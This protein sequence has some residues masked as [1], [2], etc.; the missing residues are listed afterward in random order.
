M[1]TSRTCLLILASILVFAASACGPSA[2]DDD[3][4]DGDDGGA[5]ASNCT[6][7]AATD[8]VCNNGV[9]DD[10]DGVTDC[11]DIDCS[12]RDG[13]PV[14]GGNCEVATP[15]AA[16]SLP[17]GDCTGI[18]PGPGA[19]DAELQAFLMTCS[20]YQ[21]TLGLSGF[22]A[23]ARLTNTSLFLGVCVKMEHSWIRDLQIE[24][25]CPDGNRVILSKFLGQNCPNPGAPCEVFLGVPYE[26]DEG[27]P[28]P[29]PGTGWDYCWKTGAANIPMIDYSNVTG[30]PSTVP[31]G[32]YQPS[33]PFS[34]FANCNLNGDWRIRVVDGWGID[35]G[36][37][38]ESKL[39]FDGS[40]SD[41]CPIID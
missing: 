33:E 19:T 21:A 15:S 35:D 2:R 3:G 30:A 12:G 26:A 28:T 7:V 20:S 25:Y 39:L 13:C 6:P 34:G 22:P 31:A 24:A 8:T 40:L 32:D 10:C 11:G 16:L 9:D 1:K 36:Y 14:V 4:D 17:D 18:S 27:S 38:F 29:M 41:D 37:I 5:D 23:A